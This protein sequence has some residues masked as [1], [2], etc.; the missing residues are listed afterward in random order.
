MNTLDTV[1]IAQRTVIVPER[2]DYPQIRLDAGE[3]ASG[4]TIV[5]SVTTYD[6]RGKEKATSAE[7]VALKEFPAGMS[8]IGLAKLTLIE[9]PIIEQH[10][11]MDATERE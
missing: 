5:L 1:R 9:Q 10:V 11:S 8:V 7:K 6:G 4:D 3:L 2:I